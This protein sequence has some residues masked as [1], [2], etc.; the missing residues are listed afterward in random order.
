MSEGRPPFL[1]V[2]AG[3][4]LGGR[5]GFLW[6]SCSGPGKGG[7]VQGREGGGFLVENTEGRGSPGWM[8]RVRAHRGQG[9]VCGTWMGGALSF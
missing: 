5:F 6:F 3:Q 8:G 1:D 2:D 4:T 7:G 9:G